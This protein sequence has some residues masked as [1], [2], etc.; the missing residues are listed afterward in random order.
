[1]VRIFFEEYK[2]SIIYST[3]AIV[4]VIVMVGIFH[5]TV[6]SS[7]VMSTPVSTQKII[8]VAAI[9]D[10]NTFGS[11]VVS[12]TDSSKAYP[13]QLQQLLGEQ[14]EVSNFGL[15]GR[16]L[17]STGDVPYTKE[18][19]YEQSRDMQPGVV[20]IMLG[21]ND[22]K[23]WNWNLSRYEDELEAFVESYK[24]LAS[25]PEVFL[26]TVP[27]ADENN[28][29]IRSG[30]IADEVV[31]AIVRVAAIT[32]TRV[33]DIYNVTK[34]HLSL[35]ADGVHPDT[36]GHTIIASTVYDALTSPTGSVLSRP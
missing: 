2:N 9:G 24:K 31:P 12:E 16:T 26:L 32:D 34:N 7:P 18:P 6:V 30:V 20:L 17:L 33:I 35:F 3:T 28:M 15:S 22:S 8:K 25:N 5:G 1:M 36:S 11:G 14:Y 13:G 21:T 4:G 27:A 10:S 19:A 29:G 23:P